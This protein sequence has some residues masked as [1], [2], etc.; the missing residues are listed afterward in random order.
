MSDQRKA[1]NLEEQQKAVKEKKQKQALKNRVASLAKQGQGHRERQLAADLVAFMQRAEVSQ[2]FSDHDRSLLK[3]FKYYC[4]QNKVE[5]GQDLQSRL[6]RLDFSSFNKLAIQSK[7]VPVLISS[8]Q[9]KS[10]FRNTVKQSSLSNAD[11][12]GVANVG[13]QDAASQPAA[14]NQGTG[15]ASTLDGGPAP[16]QID[17][18]SFKRALVRIAIQG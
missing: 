14:S 16:Q 3:Y 15:R 4:R 11:L 1:T 12:S 10:T 5:L 6:E 8:E 17:Y 7:I 13:G 9:L 18:E 2:L